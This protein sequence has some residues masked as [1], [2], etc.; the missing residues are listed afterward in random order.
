MFAMAVCGFLLTN[1]GVIFSLTNFCFLDEKL[2]YYF[3]PVDNID[4]STFDF[5]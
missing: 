1:S 3:V 4:G 5:K 2:F